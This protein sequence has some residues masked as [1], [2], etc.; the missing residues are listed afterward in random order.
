M[1]GKAAQPLHPTS[2]RYSGGRRSTT[3]HHKA[4][5]PE[6]AEGFT[7]STSTG[8]CSGRASIIRNHRRPVKFPARSGSL[9][10]VP[11][12]CPV[13]LLPLP[14][15]A[16]TL[17]L[18]A[19]WRLYTV[20]V[21]PVVGPWVGWWYA[22]PDPACRRYVDALADGFRS[23]GRGRWTGVPSRRI[24]VQRLIPWR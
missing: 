19:G 1:Q 3:P 23:I 11:A 22:G 7:A 5:E 4:P 15:R 16:D 2:L 21:Q 14:E 20:H 8:S 9:P 17:W 10:Q 13:G 12:R 24:V 18:P 6:T